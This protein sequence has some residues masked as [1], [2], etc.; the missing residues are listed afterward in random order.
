MQNYST[1]SCIMAGARML[2]FSQKG[3]CIEFFKFHFLFLIKYLKISLIGE[4]SII[5]VYVIKK[6]FFILHLIL[7]CMYTHFIKCISFF[8]F[9]IFLRII[10]HGYESIVNIC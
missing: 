1:I 9:I 3:W 6:S 8:Y 10:C 7:S 2:S 4:M 5:I